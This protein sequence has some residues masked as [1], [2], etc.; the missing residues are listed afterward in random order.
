[1][2]HS[3]NTIQQILSAKD[4]KPLS[5]RT[6][7]SFEVSLDHLIVERKSW[8]RDKSIQLI[9]FL[10]TN[11]HRSALH[12]EK[13]IDRIWE[14]LGTDN[15]FK[16]ALHGVN[17]VLNPNKKTRNDSRFILRQGQTYQLD[18]ANIWLDTFAFQELIKLGNQCKADESS[19]AVEAYR[20][21][22]NLYGGTYLPE[23]IYEDWSSAERERLQ[24]L[25]MNAHISL[26]QHI[27]ND[28]PDEVIRLMEKALSI[29]PLWEDAYRL[30]MSAFMKNGNR[31][32]AI[33][34]YQKCEDILMEE[35][36]VKPLPQTKNLFTQIVR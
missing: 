26:A 11:F 36:G 22:I 13:I 18:M 3:L 16:V 32:Q 12:K 28:N 15:D 14:E 20:Q 4:K 24:L 25:A 1:M 23:R 6:L 2:S 29:D 5:I 7:G 34:T 31:P 8:G 10:L 21:A 17:K 9:Q 30:K 33:L 19:I 27:E 35:L